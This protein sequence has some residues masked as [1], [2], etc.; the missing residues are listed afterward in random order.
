MSKEPPVT[1]NSLRL[2]QA[3]EKIYPVSVKGKYCRL[4]WLTMIVLLAIYYITPWLRW[5]RGPHAPDQAIL[6]DMPSRRAYFFFIEIWPQEVYYL[7]GI[8]I[9][10]AVGLFLATAMFGRIWCGYACPQ[11][12]WTDLFLVVERFFQGDGN[13]AQAGAGAAVIECCASGERPATGVFEAEWIR[14]RV[15]GFVSAAATTAD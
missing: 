14:R 15:E 6:I 9:L 1:D 12:V 5:G 4:K 7:M 10:A 3:R 8:L 13:R 11:T 2:F